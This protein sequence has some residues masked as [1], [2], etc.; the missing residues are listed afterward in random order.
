MAF[1]PLPSLLYQAMGGVA[2]S[3]FIRRR[4]DDDVTESIGQQQRDFEFELSPAA[5]QL[6]C[7]HLTPSM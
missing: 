6:I 1:K 2:S 7:P 4:D 3:F 5:Q